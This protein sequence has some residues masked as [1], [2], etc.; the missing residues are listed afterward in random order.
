MAALEET[1]K[2]L[3]EKMEAKE[4]KSKSQKKNFAW[5]DEQL[6]ALVEIVLNNKALTDAVNSSADAWEAIAQTFTALCD[7]SL[8]DTPPDGFKTAALVCKPCHSTTSEMVKGRG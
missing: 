6:E 2:A 3:A 1:R 4:A 8:W 7:A 5:S